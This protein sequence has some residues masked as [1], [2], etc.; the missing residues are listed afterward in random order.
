MAAWTP[1]GAMKAQG[2]AHDRLQRAIANKTA[3]HVYYRGCP[4]VT[5]E[6]REAALRYI[7]KNRRGV[8]S[9]VEMLP[10]ETP[11]VESL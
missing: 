10:G 1:T 11:T 9:I 6:S 3:V 5:C 8:Y 2:D 7:G 4:H